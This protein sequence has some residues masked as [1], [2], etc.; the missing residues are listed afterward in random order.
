MMRIFILTIFPEIFNDV[1]NFSI[2]KKAR[3][4][5]KVDFKILNIRD[6][7]TDK[8]KTTDDV[9]FGG[10]EGMV[11][12]VEPIFN[13]L[14]NIRQEIDKK[15]NVKTLL[16]SASGKKLTQNKLHEYSMQ[17][18]LILICGRYEGV[19]ERVINFVDEEISI[20]DYVLSGGEFPAMVLI[21][22]I[23]R[24][25][26]DVLGNSE[27]VKNESFN[28]GLLDYPQYTRPREFMGYK[29]PDVLVSGNHEEIRNWRKK[30][31]L[32][33][34]YLNRPE[35]LNPVNLNEEEKIILDKIRKGEENE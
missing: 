26:P 3:E 24:L 16:F 7:T 8:H 20:G 25:L 34:T 27:S 19:D 30:Q 28:N 13:A 29:V 2:L 21:E 18:N 32:K 9:P 14:T 22:G 15:G 11:M 31:A 10:L 23:V 6:F 35:L 17:D 33:K 5:Q 1:L 4:K 12:K